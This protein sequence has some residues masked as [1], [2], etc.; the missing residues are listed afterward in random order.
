MLITS[1]SAVEYRAFFGLAPGDT[2][3]TV[4]DC[5]AGGSSFAAETGGQVVAVDPAYALPRA[6]LAAQVRA[7]LGDTNQIIGAQSVHFDWSWYGDPARRSRLRIAAARLFLDDLRARPGRYLAGALPRLPLA[8]GSFDLV[9]CSHLLFTWSDRFGLDWHRRALAE[10]VRVARR[11]VRVFPLVVQGTGEPVPFLP[12]LRAGLEQAG[13]RTRIRTVPYR[14]QRGAN[15]M[16]SV[17]AG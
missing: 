4:L 1:R 2:A 11:E 13:H 7:S 10:L 14:F 6:E 5:C 16:L 9:L 17:A 3:A 12:E 8:P 15:Q